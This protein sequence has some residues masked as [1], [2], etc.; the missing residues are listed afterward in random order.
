MTSTLL[1][2]L[3]AGIGGVLRHGVNLAA[4]RWLGPGF[5]FN[6][7][8][9]NILGSAAM[10]LLVGW[11]ALR[12]GEADFARA[13]VLARPPLAA[14]AVLPAAPRFGAAFRVAEAA[15]VPA[16]F[17]VAALP[18]ILRPSLCFLPCKS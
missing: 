7:M 6:T 4:L 14:A 15:L 1:V 12:A 13:P 18:T 9:V 16:D 17:D 3:G 11:L 10:G 2:F 5:P 8:V